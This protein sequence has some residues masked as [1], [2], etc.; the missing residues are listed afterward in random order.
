[1]GLKKLIKQ[2]LSDKILPDFLALKLE[3][4]REKRNPLVHMQDDE[5]GYYW[6]KALS[7]D[8]TAEVLLEQD[9]KDA[10]LLTFEII[11]RRPFS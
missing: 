5:L 11:N 6:K 8:T 1:M 3:E 9:A 4:L 10:I 7:Q 2:A